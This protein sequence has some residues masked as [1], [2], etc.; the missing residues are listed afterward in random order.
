M[1]TSALKLPPALERF[2]A[3]QVKQGAYSSREA[4]IIAAVV[5]EK[6]RTEQR[7]WLQTEIQKGLESGPAVELNMEHVIRRG[8]A[9]LASRK[10]RARTG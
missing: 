8:R 7:A 2:V 4:A 3:A 9:R 6:R 1:A 10:R 5:K